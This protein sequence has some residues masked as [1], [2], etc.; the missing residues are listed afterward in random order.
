[1][2]TATWKSPSNIALVKYWGKTGVQIPCNPSLSFTLSTSHSITTLELKS[3]VEEKP[4]VTFFLEQKEKPS[5]VPKIE[6]F[7]VRI[8]PHVPFVNDYDW[9]IHSQNS[10]P[11]ST[12]IASSAS[13]LSALA[14]CVCDIEQQLYGEVSEKEFLEKASL[15]ARLGSGSA[16]SSVFGPIATWGKSKYLPESTDERAYLLPKE[17]IHPTFQTFQD[18]ILIVDGKEKAVSSTLG[19]GLMNTNPFSEARFVQAD[20]NLGKLLKALKE[21]D[22]EK[23]IHITELEALTLHSMMMTS[24]PYFTLMRPNTLEIIERIFEYRK[25][26]GIPVCFTLDAGPN[27]HLLYPLE[28]KATVQRWIETSL[29]EFLQDGRF[30]LD[31]CGLGAEKIN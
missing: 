7:I 29:T 2:L 24:S 19:H 23:F 20:E 13:G 17:E 12:G 6:Q 9:K 26:T 30:L 27:I 16:C 5:F 28:Y 15:L 4:K 22:L 18:T 3:R 31:E 21:G 8:A 1:M 14:L 11:H 10:F 25:E